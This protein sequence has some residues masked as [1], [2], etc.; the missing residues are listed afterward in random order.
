M[1]HTDNYLIYR[2]FTVSSVV[3]IFGP[4]VSMVMVATRLRSRI[5]IAITAASCV[6]FSGA[7]TTVSSQTENLVFSSMN[8]FWLNALYAIIY[9]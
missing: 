9:G 7:F 1:G 2:D 3:G 5:P 4:V 8:G 6:A